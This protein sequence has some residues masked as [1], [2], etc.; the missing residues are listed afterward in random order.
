[1]GHFPID[2]SRKMDPRCHCGHLAITHEPFASLGCRERECLEHRE[3]V[4]RRAIARANARAEHALR[5]KRRSERLIPL[6]FARLPA[7]AKRYL[8][9]YL[10]RVLRAGPGP[11]PVIVDAFAALSAASKSRSTGSRNADRYRHASGQPL[12]LA[13]SRA[14]LENRRRMGTIPELDALLG[15]LREHQ[16]ELKASGVQH[17]AIFGS[18][19]RHQASEASDV[20]VLVDLDPEARINIFDFEGIQTRLS[21]ILDRKVD[22]VSRRGL[23][24]GRHSHIE[25]E[26]VSAF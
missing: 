8:R 16:K 7:L 6:I 26:A 18:V 21:A 5:I 15:V 17:V 10:R 2:A 11:A 12:I 19:A 22:L 20:D 1:V 13:D 3:W 4:Y 23:K 24:T 14:M 25:A 9:R